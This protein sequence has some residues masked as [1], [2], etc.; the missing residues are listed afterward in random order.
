MRDPKV[1]E[2]VILMLQKLEAALYPGAVFLFLVNY[3]IIY[4]LF[5][6]KN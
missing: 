4:P 5:L 3:F 1:K 6:L 2:T